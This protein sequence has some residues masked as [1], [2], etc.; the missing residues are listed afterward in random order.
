MNEKPESPGVAHKGIG[1]SLLRKEDDR[2][3][4]GRGGYVANIRMVGMQDVAFARSPVAHGRIRGIEKPPGM[5]HAVFTLTDLAGVKPIV[6]NSGLKGFKPSAQ[7]VL[8]ADKVRQVGEMIAMCVADTRAQAEDLAAQVFVDFDELPAVVDMLDAR[9]PASA[10]VHEH[11]G[12]N[13]FLETAVGCQDGNDFDAVC[14]NA[15]IKVHRLLR[16][17][18]QSMAPMEGR[19]VV[20]DWD[21][22]LGQLIVYTAAQMPHINRTGLAACLGLDEGQVRVIAPDVGGGFGYK[23]ILLPEEVAVAWLAMRLGRPVRWIEDRREQ[24]TANANCREHDYDITAYADR[25]GRLIGIDCE[26]TVDSGAYSSYPFSAC[27]EAAQVSSILPGPYKMDRYRCRTWSVATNKPP[28]LPFR[29]VART[30]VCYAMETVMDAIA[31]EAGLEPHEVR[32][33][34]LVQADEMP[35]D[36]ITNKHFDSGDYPECV[37]RAIKAIDLDA[38]RARQQQGEPDGR[39]IGF[40]MAVFCEQ[41]AHG[42]SVYHGWGIPMVP[43]REPVNIRLSPDG[44]L[45]MRAGVHS[46]GQSMETT[47][48]QIANEVLGI[49]PGRVRVVLGDTGVTPYSTGTWGSRSIVMAGGAVGQACK[50]LKQRLLKIAAWLLKTDAAQ[51]SWEGDVAVSAGARVTLAEIAHVWYLKPQLLPPDVDARGLEVATTYQAKRDTGTFSYACHAIV[52]AVDVQLGKVE[53]LDYVIVEDGGVLINPMVVDGQVYGGAAQGIG[54]ALYEA[55]RYS[56]E[57]QP[58]ASTLAD[59]ILPGATEVPAIRIEHMETPAPYTEFGQKGIGESGAIGS[60]AAVANAVND[61]LRPL[62]AMVNELPITP[63]VILDAL[64][65]VTGATAAERKVA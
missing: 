62:G 52:A 65:A 42:T 25:D 53:L 18:R 58:L 13:V 1:A 10:L 39:R 9:L 28:I 38:V 8:A 35:F 48:A 21:R 7:P 46:H 54:T 57:G 20:A 59:Y 45:E 63:R 50:E 61:A 14:R 36:N 29:G 17:A 24:L 41:G 64:A 43:G 3:M 49:D 26:A 31:V 11:W 19:G 2:F 30:G 23:G 55:M 34:N 5:E 6:A 4:R 16:T 60:T 56:P 47:L 32:L 22:R 51:V 44:I 37:R 40:G 27:L 33:R 15:P 12:D